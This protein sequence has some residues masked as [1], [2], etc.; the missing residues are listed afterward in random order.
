MDVKWG[1]EP[2]TRKEVILM[3]VGFVVGETLAKVGFVI[4]GAL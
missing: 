1:D 3:F 2:V 4:L